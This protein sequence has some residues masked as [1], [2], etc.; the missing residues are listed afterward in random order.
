MLGRLYPY[1]RPAWGETTLGTLLLVLAAGFEVLQPWPI[2]WLVDYVFGGRPA[3]HSLGTW[4]PAFGTGDRH[5][6]I[7]GVCLAIILLAIA[8]RLTQV[9]SQQL[10]ISSGA[11]VVKELRRHAADHVHRLDLA[12][13]DRTK[14]GDSI[15]RLAYDTAAALSFVS[16]GVAPV[17]S[18]ALVLIGVVALMLRLDWMLTLVAI[19]VV[20][21]FWLTIHCFG[22]GIA[23]RAEQYHVHESA[24]VTTLQES[25]SSIRVIQAFS[26]EAQA[27]QRVNE[28]AGLSLKAIQ[29]LVLTQLSFSACVGLAM[30]LGTAAIVG[31]GAQRVMNGH[32]SLGDIL[33]FLAYL[34]ML[35]Q[36]MNA[37]SQSAGVV[38]ASKVQLKRVFEL[39][40]ISSNVSDR[41]HAIVLP[42][43]SGRIQFRNVSF[44]YDAGR[45][46]VCD[47]SFEVE[48][49]HVVAVVGR[50]G[51]GKSTLASLLIRFY[52]PTS[53]AVLLDGHDLR[54]LKLQW[55]RQQ[56]S[57]V[58]QEPIL[59]SATIR[60]NLAYARPDAA[61]AD[62][63]EAARRAQAD[64]FIRSLPHGYNTM[65]G[66]RGVNLS[67]GQRQRMVI[68]RAFLK[69]APILIL[70]EPTSALD[71]H[72]EEALVAS[73]QQLMKGR[74]TFIIA[75]RLSTVRFANFIL[76]FENGR[77]IEQGTH[78]ELFETETAYRRMYLALLGSAEQQER[79]KFVPD[80]RC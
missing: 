1:W 14:V 80:C 31:M 22:Q 59:F 45:S 72:T 11:R 63:E 49:G 70:D 51:S 75:H 64:E 7:G 2:K 43:V 67:G 61:M 42:T 52:D 55:L 38:Q 24:L 3:P 18:G 56:I 34:G 12:Y 44:G 29:R 26:R 58:L 46:V 32:L 54:D 21:I 25:L 53:G 17:A 19:A 39:L 20:P 76:V 79:A 10:L 71:A 73:L 9:L 28:Q 27:D 57:I 23:K 66:E 41:A 5:G 74:T 62:I 65:L 16:Q 35:Y 15:Y 78:D 68:A 4:W 33:V 13:H 8:H 50:T 48:P 40:D 69:N 30:A 47:T 36:P 77:I 6:M 37:F 60:E